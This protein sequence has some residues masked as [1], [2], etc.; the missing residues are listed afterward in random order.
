MQIAIMLMLLDLS[1]DMSCRLALT[2][3]GRLVIPLEKLGIYRIVTCNLW[4]WTFMHRLHLSICRWTTRFVRV[5]NIWHLMCRR[6]SHS[7]IH[8][9]PTRNMRV[10]PQ[11]CR[12][13]GESAMLLLAIWPIVLKHHILHLVRLIVQ[14]DMQLKTFMTRLTIVVMA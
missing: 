9:Q 14:W 12:W 3:K 13:M 6:A 1:M 11:T 7:F 10:H 5:I 2:S 4:I 8:R